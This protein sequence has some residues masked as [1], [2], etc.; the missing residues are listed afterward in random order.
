[1]KFNIA[2]LIFSIFLTTFLFGQ[3][4]PS[5]KD[6]LTIVK[7]NEQINTLITNKQ[8]LLLKNEKITIEKNA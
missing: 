7:C 6:S 2:T 8:N 4:T 3:N 1:M 5:I